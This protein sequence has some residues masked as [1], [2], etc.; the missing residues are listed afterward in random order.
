M[1]QRVARSR[2]WRSQLVDRATPIAAALT[3][4]ALIA[5]WVE[6]VVVALRAA[7]RRS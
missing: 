2:R 3:V 6:Q 1:L 5:W 7:V 4:I